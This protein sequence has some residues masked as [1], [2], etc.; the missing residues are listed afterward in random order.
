MPGFFLVLVL[1]VSL[2]KYDLLTEPE[3]VGLANY[4]DVLTDPVFWRSA[5]ATVI[6]VFGTC[7]SIW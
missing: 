7:V 6:Y 2:F 4:K 5:L 1:G 3:F